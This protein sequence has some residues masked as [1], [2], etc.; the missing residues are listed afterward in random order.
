MKM[1]QYLI[2]LSIFVNV[3]LTNLFRSIGKVVGT[4]P[5]ITVCLCIVMTMAFGSG[6]AQF[7]TE[8][9]P[10]KLFVPDGTRALA[11]QEDMIKYFGEQ[12]SVIN[13]MIL[14]KEGQYTNILEKDVLGAV[15]D[16]WNEVKSLNNSQYEDICL[17]IT[18][19]AGPQCVVSSVLQPWYYNKANFDA[20][21]DILKTINDTYSI[22]TLE[23]LIGG[24]TLLDGAATAAESLRLIAIIKSQKDDPDSLEDTIVDTWQEAMLDIALNQD[25]ITNRT[26]T[27]F[28]EVFPFCSVAFS[29]EVG[30]AIT[31]DVPYQSASYM[32][33]IF[34]VIFMLQTRCDRVN[35]SVAIALLGV[36]SIGLGIISAFGLCQYLGFP[37]GN[38]HTVLPFII[39]GVGVDGCFILVNDFDRTSRK[40]P[41]KDR[42]AE[43]LANAGVSLTVTSMT[44]VAAFAIGSLTVIPDLS[45]FCKYAAL[46]QLFLWFYHNTFYVACL[47]LNQRRIAKQ[48]LDILCCFTDCRNTKQQ[49]DNEEDEFKPSKMSLWMKNVY[50]HYLL[51]NFIRIPIIII[52]LGWVG[53][54]CYNITLLSVEATGTNFIPDGS[55]LKENLDLQSKYFSGANTDVYV[56]TENFD[57]FANREG[58]YTLPSH[59][60]NVETSVPYILSDFE[61]WFEIFVTD[62]S[63]VLSGEITTSW[64]VN[65]TDVSIDEKVSNQSFPVSSELFYKYLHLWLDDPSLGASFSS[66]IIFTNDMRTQI[67]RARTK[68]QHPAIGYT[69]ESGKFIKEDPEKIVAA[70]DEMYRIC[71]SFPFPT[72]PYSFAYV[73]DWASYAIIEGE[74]VQ[75]VSLALAAVFVVTM[76]LI[77]HPGTSMLVFL[78]VSFTIIELLGIQTL[79]DLSIDTVAVVLFVLAVGLSV[80]Y[81]AHIAQGFMQKTG[82][83]SERVALVLEDIGV[84]VFNGGIST[85]LAICLQGLSQSYVFRVVFLDFFFA[86]LFGLFNGLV[87][88]P[89]VLSLIGPESYRKHDPV[90]ATNKQSND[91]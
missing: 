10:E 50:A 81:S 18:T 67:Q 45:S 24:I 53:Y 9:R 19:P 33:I 58:L 31:S 1:I 85:F 47:V 90:V 12:N 80:D 42:A 52:S 72:Y 89:I 29:Q 76:I 75:N 48:K 2:N 82:T 32:I 23:T 22:D 56:V 88:L 37:Y 51:M 8:S 79:F 49:N 6:L 27:K 65:T 83:R 41:L 66:N 73:N 46:A 43:A 7:D 14:P 68:M 60:R 16:F 74:L 87:L 34:Y 77:G 54:C 13:F 71:D 86:V 11:D 63:K 84:P 5:W 20:D 61:Y 15:F 62:I 39:L 28:I 69:D 57:Y 17:S 36:L 78:S 38:T 35:G 30:G 44:N 40:L 3:K 26:W 4:Y 55:Y 70:V 64:M 25:G 21:S 91:V 59:F